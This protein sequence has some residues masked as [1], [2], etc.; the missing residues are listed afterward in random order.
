MFLSE[1]RH[2][3]PYDQWND[4]AIYTTTKRTELL[5]CVMCPWA[6]CRRI[7]TQFFSLF[8]RLLWGHFLRE[9]WCWVSQ[10]LCPG[11]FSLKPRSLSPY[12]IQTILG[13]VSVVGTVPALYFIEAWGR[14]KVRSCAKIRQNSISRTSS[15]CFLVHLHKQFVRSSCVLSTF[16]QH[17]LLEAFFTGRARRPFLSRSHWNPCLGVD[18]ARQ[19]S[20]R[21]GHRVRGPSGLHLW[22]DVGPDTLGVPR[23][24]LPA[25]CPT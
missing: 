23:R 11:T 1:K 12:V 22:D 21:C 5:L 24:V 25:P 13:A 3:A 20:W 6:V 19:G 14:R 4:A 2:V 10:R 9:C 7:S 16:H 17:P 15:R 8:G 18:I